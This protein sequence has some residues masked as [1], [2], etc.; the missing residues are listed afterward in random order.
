[1][2]QC[3]QQQWEIP[4]SRSIF[5]RLQ[6]CF[7]LM[8]I[9]CTTTISPLNEQ[10][11]RDGRVRHVGERLTL[12]IK[13]RQD[14][15]Q[16]RKGRRGSIRGRKEMEQEVQ[17]GEAGGGRGGGGCR[18][19][20]SVLQ[21][22]IPF[23]LTHPSTPVSFPLRVFLPAIPDSRLPLHEPLIKSFHPLLSASFIC[24]LAGSTSLSS[25]A[26]QTFPSWVQ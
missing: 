16:E 3:G 18:R 4:F 17:K 22:P 13:Q 21:S 5:D 1:M 23:P 19:T 15:R 7:L 20:V 11:L 25:P 10:N 8:V 12:M 24:G 9:Y 2:L 14:S 26:W 6:H